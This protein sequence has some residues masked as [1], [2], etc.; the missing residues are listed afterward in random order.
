VSISDAAPRPIKEFAMKINATVT[1]LALIIAGGL[2]APAHHARA[3]QPC[4]P[5]AQ[6]LCHGVQPGGG[7][8]VACLKQHESEL[9]PQCQKFVAQS[10]QGTTAAAP[11]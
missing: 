11:K 8:I 10:T 9:S 5:D 4:R 6:K 1:A 2:L 3:E 7:R